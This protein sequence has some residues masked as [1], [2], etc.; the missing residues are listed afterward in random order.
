MF[1]LLLCAYAHPAAAQ[2]KFD[3]SAAAL[4]QYDSNVFRLSSSGQAYDPVSAKFDDKRDDSILNGVATAR[5]E[6]KFD[7][8]RIYLNGDGTRQWYHHYKVLDHDEYNAGGGFD[9]RATDWVD[10]SASAHQ[11]HRMVPQ[12]ARLLPTLT[13]AMQKDQNASGGINFTAGKLWRLETR[14]D[15]QKQ[16]APSPDAQFFMNERDYTVAG[17]YLGLGPA[18]VGLQVQYIDGVFTAPVLPPN[19]VVTPANYRTF[20]LG[21]SPYHQYNEDLTVD[22]TVSS[23]SSFTTKLGVSQRRD[24][25]GVQPPTN[26]FTGEL[27]YKRTISPLTTLTFALQ[28]KL[29]SYPSFNDF[30]VESG[31]YGQLEWRPTLKIYT[32]LLAQYLEDS[33]HSADRADRLALVDAGVAYQVFEHF[34]IKPGFHYEDRRSSGGVYSYVDRIYSMEAKLIF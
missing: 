4:E 18:A 12:S 22:Y 16:D 6:Y 33:F 17:K 13:V 11:D 23:L 24:P 19:T 10:G 3:A 25:Q 26:G 27:Q 34:S 2:F 1:C 8:Q 32:N 30:V 28:R 14:F 15:W 29:Q 5:L 21:T 20:A 9:W 31:G 7:D